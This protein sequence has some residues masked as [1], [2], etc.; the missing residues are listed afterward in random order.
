[1]NFNN[2]KKVTVLGGGARS[3]LLGR[4]SKNEGTEILKTIDVVI[5]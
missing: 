3:V 4:E 5:N 2:D 1:M